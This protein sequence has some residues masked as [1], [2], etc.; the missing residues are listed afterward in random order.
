MLDRFRTNVERI[1]LECESLHLLGNLKKI[2]LFE[3]NFGQVAT[4]KLSEITKIVWL[5]DFLILITVIVYV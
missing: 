1:G 5:V 3:G 4:I 2:G